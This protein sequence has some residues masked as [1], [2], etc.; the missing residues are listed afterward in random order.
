MTRLLPHFFACCCPT[1]WAAA[2]S[3]NGNEEIA[4]APR[5]EPHH[6]PTERPTTAFGYNG[7]APDATPTASGSANNERPASTL[8]TT[9]KQGNGDA[10]TDAPRKGAPPTRCACVSRARTLPETPRLAATNSGRPGGGLVDCGTDLSRN[11]LRSLRSVTDGRA[12]LY[13]PVFRSRVSV[14]IVAGPE[15]AGFLVL[16]WLWCQ[17]AVWWPWCET[18]CWQACE[19]Q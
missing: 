19:Q 5:I 14:M 7:A 13:A 15:A 6:V 11:P 16:N 1:C 18:V 12:I 3:G 17:R 10:R 4:S 9:L 8:K 2:P